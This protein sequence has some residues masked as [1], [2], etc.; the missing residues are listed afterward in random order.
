MGR[1]GGWPSRKGWLNLEPNNREEIATDRHFWVRTDR[2]KEPLTLPTGEGVSAT[3]GL[4]QRKKPAGIAL[5]STS[6][7]R[8]GA[9]TYL[10]ARLSGFDVV[11]KW[12]TYNTV[13]KSPGL[14]LIGYVDGVHIRSFISIPR[15]NRG[16]R[17][18]V[19]EDLHRECEDDWF[20]WADH[21]FKFKNL[22][23]ATLAKLMM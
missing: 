1:H 14:D 4:I 11:V 10:V 23:D 20:I 22:N 19:V 5:W 7:D 8:G 12:W 17:D 2:P 21:A 13:R 16:W 3:R 9:P 6:V 18:G 15:I